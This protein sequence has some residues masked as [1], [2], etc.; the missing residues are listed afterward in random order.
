MKQTTE[1]AKRELRE[2][3]DE[4]IDAIAESLHL[5]DVIDWLNERLKK[6]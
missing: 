6:S 5:Y 4:L 1:E 2:A 3:V